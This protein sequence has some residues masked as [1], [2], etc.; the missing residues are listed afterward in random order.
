NRRRNLRPAIRL[1][2]ARTV[3]ELRNRHATKLMIIHT[4]YIPFA[5]LLI[6]PHS[7][8]LTIKNSTLA[9]FTIDILTSL[10]NP[11]CAIITRNNHIV[12]R[13]NTHHNVRF[14]L[15]PRGYGNKRRTKNQRIKMSSGRRNIQVVCLEYQ[16]KLFRI[17]A[18]EVKTLF[19]SIDNSSRPAKD[20]IN[21][22]HL[23]RQR[24]AK[25]FQ[26]GF[27]IVILSLLSI[28]PREPRKI[29]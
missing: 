5:G 26:P 13:N 8:H 14:A 3:N 18:L 29:L 2:S 4:V 6:K 15:T 19:Q 9:I 16:V 1:R 22:P 7:V 25:I 20:S 21:K 12:R 24:D 11:P 28:S 17:P 23:W 27:A 10:N